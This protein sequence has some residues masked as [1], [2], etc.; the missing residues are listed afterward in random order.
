ME[1]KKTAYKDLT[2]ENIEYIKHVYYQGML[3]TEKME[4]LSKKF[5]VSERTVR[6]WWKKLDL[7][8]LVTD[9]SPQ[10]QKAQERVLN[11]GTKVLLVTTAQNK[12]AVNKDFLNN[13]IAYQEYITNTLGKETEIVIIP[14]RYRNPTN[15][16]EDEKTKTSDWWDDSISDYLF[17]GKV[18]F[19][20]T[21]ISADSSISP[22]AKSPLDGFEILASDNN[23]V[24]GHSKV[25]FRTLPRFRNAPLRTMSTTG[26]LTSKNYSKSKAGI[27]AGENHSY[28][29][30]IIELK[31]ESICYIPRNVKVKSDGSFT[32]I[33]HCV[34][35]ESVSQI[36]KSLGFIL[37]DAHTRQLNRDFLKVTKELIAKTNPE[38]TVCHDL[39]DS[40][41][42]NHH[43]KKDMFIQRQKI[44]QG[45]HLVDEE[46]EECLDFLEELKGCCGDIYAVESN[47]DVWLD[48]YISE[49]KWQNDLHNS[50]AY[51]KY[52]YIQQTVDLSMYGNILGYLIHQRFDESVKYVKMGDSLIIG[53][54][55]CGLHLDFGSNGGRASVKGFAR[56][57]SKVIGGH[58][59]SPQLYNNV[60]IVGILCNLQQ[61]YNRKGLS[62]W[63]YAHSIVHENGKNQ[64]LVFNDDYTLSGL[65]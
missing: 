41:T 61:Y 65:I 13:L 40:A 26:Y 3:H 36:E 47:H 9:L 63:A 1:Y 21:L 6:G 39:L 42:M 55:E 45:K 38:K 53:D 11:K 33:I 43:E 19:G 5:G 51:L 15:N 14:S 24:L 46:I 23:L 56:L 64:L 20:D 35:N 30:I 25:H 49:S 17:Y 22:T 50:P 60:T 62:S 29:F 48:K 7:S 8:K 59:H 44:V 18:N 37:G 16:V 57:N 27:V 34:K 28:G 32:D 2:P 10:L 31:D 52:A 12:T 54:Y 58:A 4:I